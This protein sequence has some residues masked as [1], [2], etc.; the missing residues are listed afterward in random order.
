MPE[1]S[2]AWAKRTY[3]V[4]VARSPFNAAPAVKVQLTPS[5]VVVGIKLGVLW[6]ILKLKVPDFI[7]RP[8]GCCWMAM[9][10]EVT[11]TKPEAVPERVGRA[12]TPGRPGAGTVMTAVGAVL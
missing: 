1:A 5:K 11:A 4:S 12:S 10:T 3:W 2:V 9:V 7:Q 8:E 6:E